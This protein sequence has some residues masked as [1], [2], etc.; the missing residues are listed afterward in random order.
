MKYAIYYTTRDAIVQNPL[1]MLIPE[2]CLTREIFENNYYK[3]YEDEANDTSGEILETLFIRFNSDQNPLSAE[4][5]QD[6]IIKNKLHTSMFVGDVIKIDDKYYIV[7][8]LG[9]SSLDHLNLH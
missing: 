7:A 2:K 3:I 8:N 1:L 5:Y 6:E 4:S 9:F